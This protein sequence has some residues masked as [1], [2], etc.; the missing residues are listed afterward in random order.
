MSMLNSYP[1]DAGEGAE[2][3]SWLASLNKVQKDGMETQ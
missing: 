1:G 2:M 3:Q